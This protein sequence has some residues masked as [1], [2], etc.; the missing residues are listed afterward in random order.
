MASPNDDILLKDGNDQPFRMRAKDVSIAQDG[1]R[2]VV[3][4]LATPYPVDYG[5][6]GCFHMTTASGTMAAGLAS[7]SPIWGFRWTSSPL[8]AIIRRLQITMW[9]GATGFTPGVIGFS[10]YAAR[11]WSAD[12]SG[13]TLATLTGD[14][15]KLRTAMGSSAA[16]IRTASTG[17]LTAGTRTLD[18]Q[19]IVNQLATISSAVST[20]FMQ[21]A[22]LLT[23]ALGGDH[24]VVL[25]QNEGVVLTVNPPATGVWSFAIEAEWD[26]VPVANY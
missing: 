7:G 2:Q 19:Q 1:S 3:R 14:N 11:N 17:A 8:L 12:D 26:E 6:G 9:S 10:L 23:K 25:A 20:V 18:A 21:K 16:A 24:P 4:H 15:G 22:P 5:T 13:G